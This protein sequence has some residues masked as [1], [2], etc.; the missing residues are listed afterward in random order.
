MIK[1]YDPRGESAVQTQPY[2]LSC[3]IQTNEGE[4]ITVALLA[5][6][7]PD[8]DIF[9]QAVG[10]ALKERLPKIKTK[11]WNKGDA[12]IPANEQILNEIQSSCQ[13]AIAAYGH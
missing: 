2:E 12:S 10:K 1:F 13:V 5:N 6:G 8:S 9:V 11:F 3:D 4:G 7:F